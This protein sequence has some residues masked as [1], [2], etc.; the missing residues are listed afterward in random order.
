MAALSRTHALEGLQVAI[1]TEGEE[2]LTTQCMLSLIAFSPHWL[3][4]FVKVQG[5]AAA[6]L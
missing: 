2:D 3:Q 6:E 4:D 5:L 1:A